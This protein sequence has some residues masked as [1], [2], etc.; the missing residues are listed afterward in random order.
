MS[1]ASGKA[2]INKPRGRESFSTFLLK[3]D[4]KYQLWLFI[5]F[6]II[7]FC[8]LTYLYPYP[9]SISDSG[10]YVNAALANR[11]DTFRPWGY[12][13]FLILIHSFSGSIHFLIFAQYFI[14]TISSLFLIFT[15]KYFFKPKNN[16]IYFG[17]AFFAICS[18]LTI[19]LSN[20]VLSDSLFTSLTIIWI[21]SGLW[22]LY[23]HKAFYKYLFYAIH[24]IALIF[25]VNVRY[26]GFIYLIITILFVFITFYKKNIYIC[27]F[28]SIA[29]ILFVY[30]YYKTQKAKVYEL[31]QVDTF[32]GFSG[33][34]LANNALHC[35]PYVKLD[36]AKITDIEVRN[37]TKLV[38]QYDSSLILKKEPSAKFM[39]DTTMPLKRYCFS[40]IRRTQRHYLVVWNYLGQNVYS[41]FGS[42][43]IKNHPI[44]FF[45]HFLLPNLRSALYPTHDQIVGA[46][47]CKGIPNNAMKDWFGIEDMTEVHS[48]TTILEK[49]SFLIPISRLLLWIFVFG[50]F[51]IYIMI[52]KRISWLPY[53]IA[54]FWVLFVFISIYLAFSVYAGP[55]ELRY[56][57]P[58]HL[59]QLSFIYIMLN[60]TTINRTKNGE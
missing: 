51:T 40:E 16:I 24:L 27:L 44:S 58:L 59:I 15:V 13:Q 9:A 21:A 57:A 6:Y 12:S 50:V 22:I 35:V 25:L 10:G 38:M 11:T 23:D 8:L 14:N 30:N 31:T 33:W 26:T 54:V 46:F 2:N 55:F 43:V 3:K 45:Q 17:Y 41:E 32:S 29:P 34:Q 1:K 47:V 18:P 48:R 49:G 37:F 60:A 7:L 39:W 36:T 42:Y 28:L 56:T 4:Q 53:Q 19:Y 20:T 5:L 52:R